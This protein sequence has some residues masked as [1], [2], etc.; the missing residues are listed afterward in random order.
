MPGSGITTRGIRI[1]SVFHEVRDQANNENGSWDQN[2]HRFWNQG[3][4]FWVK[5][6]DQ[7]RKNI[8]RY[9]PVNSQRNRRIVL[10]A[11]YSWV[12]KQSTD[13]RDLWY[14]R[15]HNNFIRPPSKKLVVL[16]R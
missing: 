3:S 9:D 14:A 2:S 13:L 11:R 7:L 6:S 10:H 8:P 15:I 4:P 1:S 5:I 16:V 12:S